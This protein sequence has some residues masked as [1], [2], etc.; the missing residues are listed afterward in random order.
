MFYAVSVVLFCPAKLILIIRQYSI[1]FISKLTKMFSRLD[2]Q[3]VFVAIKIMKSI[4]LPKK[5]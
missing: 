3:F 5:K 2:K 4:L 1:V